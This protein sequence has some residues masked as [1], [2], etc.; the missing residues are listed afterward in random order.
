MP[1]KFSSFSRLFS[2]WK[3]RAAREEATNIPAPKTNEDDDGAIPGPSSVSNMVALAEGELIVSALAPGDTLSVAAPSAHEPGH[4]EAKRNIW[5]EAFEKLPSKLR[6]DLEV[7][8]M[9]TD[10]PDPLNLQIEAF[11]NEAKLQ[12][13]RS[14]E[15]DWKV[16]IGRHELQVRQLTV[17]ITKWAT[18]IGDVAIKFAPSPGAGVWAVGVDTF[19]TEKVA[20]L[21]VVDRVSSAIFRAEVYYEIYTLER[22]QRADVVQKL[23]DAMVDL[24]G[25]VLELLAK[26]SDLSSRTAIQFCH[27]IFDTQK[28][29][30]I[31][32]QLEEYEQALQ[33]NA[34]Y[35]EITANAH[36]DDS[37]KEY[38]QEAQLFLKNFEQYMLII[39]N[40]D[41]EQLMEWVSKVRYGRHF[42]E[43]EEK[44]SPETGN[45]LI[46]HTH[47]QDW[48]KSPSSNILWLQGYPG[49]GKTFLTSAVVRHFKDNMEAQK[50]G[51]AFFFCNHAETERR[52]TLSILQSLVRQL[53]AP[54]S[55]NIAVRKSLQEAR[56]RAVAQSSHLGLSECRNQLLESLDL[57]STTVIIVDALDEVSSEEIHHLTKELDYIMSQSRDKT[58][59]LFISSRPEEAIRIAYNLSPTITINALDN[60]ADIEKV[61]IARLETSQNPKVNGRKEEIAES[62]LSNC[63]NVFLLVDLQIK[64]I[65][66]CKT[67]DAIDYE[68]KNIPNGLSERYD[69]IFSD[70]EAHSLLDAQMAKRTLQWVISAPELL[71]TDEIVC[72]ARMGIENN[73]IAL[74][75]DISPES[76]LAICENLL[77]VD[78]KGQWR[79]F[80]L[81]VRDYLKGKPRF[82]DEAHSQSITQ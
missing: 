63:D 61:L 82:E 18:K 74:K 72:A 43:I 59:K 12:Q 26:S 47:F 28:P 9:R 27:A 4:T 65:L 73:E 50:N 2:K 36:E 55:N 10:N 21:S 80:H 46:E 32:S 16:R 37:L 49:T 45:W 67:A 57:Y 53:A 31:L 54:K 1:A 68:L 62:I 58:V 13:A 35:C 17:S 77:M 30:G 19:D 44:R 33:T 8:G 75:S 3:R 76:L 41:R 42:D 24:Y 52:E 39:D 78:S 79:F 60:R 81:S 23:H 51:L 6:E 5:R 22:T 40:Y 29:S 7:R 66:K 70:I 20:L 25:C 15:R 38:L 14:E 64:Q 11:Q 71:T 56:G 69:R 34:E 48:I